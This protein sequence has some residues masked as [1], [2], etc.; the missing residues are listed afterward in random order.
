MN[1]LL[2]LGGLDTLPR[3]PASDLK[4]LGWRGVMKTV[5]REGKIV[6]TNHNE[7]EAVILSTD[8]YS[9]IV[10]ELARSG[11]DAVLETLRHRFD[12]CLAA[13]QSTDVSDRLRELARAPARLDGRVKAGT[14]H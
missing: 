7:P 9:A 4:R 12:E 11:D 10:R 1:V 6:V 2:D 13:L 5:D 14:G 8:E 3:T